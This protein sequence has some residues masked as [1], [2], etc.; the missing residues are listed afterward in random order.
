[1]FSVKTVE[2]C[3][4]VCVQRCLRSKDLHV[5]RDSIVR[6]VCSLQRDVEM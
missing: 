3:A 4:S 5:Y 6:A 1:M 2:L